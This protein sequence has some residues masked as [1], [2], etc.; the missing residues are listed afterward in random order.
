MDTLAAT[1][2]DSG[3]PYKTLQSAFRV[4]LGLVLDH[5]YHTRGGYKLSPA[6]KRRNETLTANNG[7]SSV[8]KL[9]KNG[10]SGQE[11]KNNGRNLTPLSSED[12][13]LQRRQR[14]MMLL[15][16]ASTHPEDSPRRQKIAKKNDDPPF[17]IQRI[18]EVLVAPERVSHM[19]SLK[20]RFFS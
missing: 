1:S 17:T 16:P 11:N 15:L 18:A 2:W 10:V 20:C 19:D 14:L 9:A 7:G 4:A 13:F 12:V 3:L 8:K 6:E 5:F